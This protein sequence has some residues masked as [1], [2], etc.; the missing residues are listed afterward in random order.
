MEEKLL[1]GLELRMTR[2]STAC[3]QSVISRDFHFDFFGGKIKME[4][5]R[6]EEKCKLPVCELISV[7]SS[8]CNRFWREN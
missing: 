3:D 1:P 5:G 6:K 2:E 8:D 4:V 7:F